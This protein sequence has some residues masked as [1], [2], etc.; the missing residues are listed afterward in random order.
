M[1]KSLLM[2]DTDRIKSYVFAT[3]KLREIRAASA[4]LDQLNRQE[5][6]ATAEQAGKKVYANGGSGL[7]LV[8]TAQ[9][10]PI[11]EQVEAK[12]RA[13]TTA[14]SITGVDV[15]GLDEPDWSETN[16]SPQFE[17]LGYKLQLAKDKQQ[18][19]IPLLTH[20]FLNYC[21]SCGLEYA[22]QTV[23]ENN[24]PKLVCPGCGEKIRYDRDDIKNKIP[25][26]VDAVTNDQP[27]YKKEDGLWPY[28]IQQL[29][30]QNY[31]Y[32]A[33]YDRPE[34][35]DELA[36]LSQPKEYLG[37][38][39]ADGDAMGQQLERICTLQ[40]MKDFADAVDDSIYEATV[41]AIGKHLQPR[42]SQQ[43]KQW[44]FDILLLGGDDLVMVTRAESALEVALLVMER[45]SQLANAAYTEREPYKSASSK[46]KPLP[47]HLSVGVTIAHANYPFGELLRL[48]E[49][50]LKFAKKEAARRRQ[51]EPDF[52]EGMLN[53]LVVSSAN[54]LSFDQFYKDQLRVKAE[55]DAPRPNLYRSLR[56][57]AASEF[58]KLIKAA[59]VLQDLGTPRTKLE[60]LRTLLFQ[61]KQQ[62]MVDA[63]SL[64]F[65]WR[66]ERQRRAIQDIVTQFSPKEAETGLQFPWFQANSAEQGVNYRTPL[67]DLIEIYDFIS[68][69]ES[70]DGNHQ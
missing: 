59:R 42:S 61:T 40:Q 12:Y 26:Y 44:P 10:R 18:Q 41:E 27:D 51:R 31:G 14:A 50:A 49:S 11:K 56:P 32:L 21:R 70:A 55:Y 5:M 13:A 47:L 45:F 23:T 8:E 36:K 67:L 15:N 1:S 22:A 39:Y 19:A 35:F 63:L 52:H 24:Q 37:L 20:S 30:N 58:K 16:V 7:F 68:R 69:E 60:Q 25:G 48:S 54:H 38:I 2:F 6:V 65:H 64:L 43:K 46:C 66:S 57:Y 34:T 3:D 53:F 28:L 17:T 29:H 33:G 62:A 9:V 4:I